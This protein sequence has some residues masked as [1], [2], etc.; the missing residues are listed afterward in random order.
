M[1]DTFDFESLQPGEHML[2]WLSADPI[3]TITTEFEAILSQQVPGSRLLGLHARGKPDW[4]TGAVPT[5]GDPS[6]AILV[7]TGLAFEFALSVRTPDGTVHDLA[8][9]FSRVGVH[10]NDPARTKQRTWFDLNGD[11]ATFGAEG[12]LKR[13]M[14]F[15]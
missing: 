11:L 14:Y 2:Q 6:K 13:R 5:E 1:I 12:E 8:G 7:R 9:V 10:L 15:A 3:A 4:L